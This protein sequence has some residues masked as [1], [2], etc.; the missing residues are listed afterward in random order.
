MARDCG[1]SRICLSTMRISTAMLHVRK[2]SL[3]SARLPNHASGLPD[4]AR[5]FVSGVPGESTQILSRRTELH[6]HRLLDSFCVLLGLRFEIRVRRFLP[7]RIHG[8]KR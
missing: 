7:R 1:S 6:Y 4:S 2:N 5:S 8:I 3:G